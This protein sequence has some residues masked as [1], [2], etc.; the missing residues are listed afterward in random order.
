MSTQ[1]Y[2]DYLAINKHIYPEWLEDKKHYPQT[3]GQWLE[4]FPS[5]REVIP[6]KIYEWEEAR[7]QL[8]KSIAKKKGFIETMTDPMAKYLANSILLWGEGRKLIEI[9]SQLERLMAYVEKYDPSDRYTPQE[10]IKAAESDFT[11]LITTGFIH[12]SGR[13]KTICPFHKEKTPSFVIYPNNSYYCFGC[14]ESGDAITFVQ[15]IK[16]LNFPEAINYLLNHE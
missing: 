1:N 7:Q 6:T 13:Q 4:A 10:I 5:A 14:G 3:P 12:S 2:E 11:H 8:V 9:E 16:D 15:K